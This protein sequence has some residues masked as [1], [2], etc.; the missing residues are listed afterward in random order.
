MKGGGIEAMICGLANEMAKTEDVTVCSIFLP[1]ANA[2]FWN[3]LVPQ[4]KRISLGKSKPGFSISEIFKIYNFI[5]KGKFDV[6]NLH[7]FFYYYAFSVLFLH[8]KIKFFYTVHSDANK[9]NFG[10]EKRFFVLKKCFFKWKWLHPITIS[11][12]SKDSFTHLYGI[13]SRLIYNGIPQVGVSKQDLVNEYRI[14][15]NTRIFIHAGRISIEKNQVVLC[16]V[17]KSLIEQKLDVVLL[18][19]GSIQDYKIYESLE[20]HFCERIVYLGERNDIPQLMASCDAMCLPSIWEGL[21]VTLLEA[22]S[23]GCVPICSPVG[24]IAN[25]IVDGENGYLSATSQEE[26]YYEKIKLFLSLETQHFVRMKQKCIESFANYDIKHTSRNYL[27][28][29]RQ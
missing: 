23:V 28:Y 17:F 12:A 21:P 3:K 29:Y 18:I 4:V 1:K 14:T 10:W 16:K 5:K 11:Q 26:D 20:T 19:A 8:R 9:E 25:V 27:E 15:P 22:L 13:D 7:G 2:V 6:V 24:G